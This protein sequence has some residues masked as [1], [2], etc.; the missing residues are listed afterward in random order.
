MLNRRSVGRS[1]VGTDSIAVLCHGFL[2]HKNST[3]NQALATRLLD[4][5]IATFRFD[6]FGHGR[7]TAFANLTTTIG[8]SQT[9]S[10]L[11]HLV[12]RGY[13][14]T[15]PGRVSFGGL[16]S[17][18]AAAAE[19]TRRT[20]HRQLP[21][22]R[23]PASRSNVPWSTLVKSFVLNLAGR[24]YKNGNKRIV[25]R[26]ARRPNP[27]SAGLWFHDLPPGRSP[28]TRRTRSPPNLIVQGN[29]D[30]YV[31]LHQSQRLLHALSGPKRGNS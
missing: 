1:E 21:V 5:G 4:Q 14:P 25:F 19:W 9:I 7:A 20:T 31:P 30:E 17:I 13:P 28:T 29:Q 24:D 18:L 3:S 15:R 16:L 8:V 22:R 27:Y 23:S 12:A 10:V 11:Q 26:S 6:C 2:S